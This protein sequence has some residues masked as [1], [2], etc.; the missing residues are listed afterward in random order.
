MRV[1]GRRDAF[2]TALRSSSVIPLLIELTR[3]VQSAMPNSMTPNILPMFSRATPYKR[4]EFKKILR[5]GQVSKWDNFKHQIKIS[6]KI[7]LLEHFLACYLPIA[8]GRTEGFILFSKALL[9]SE[10]QTLLSRIWTHVTNS[11]SYDNHYVNWN[12]ETKA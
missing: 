6:K 11:I 8:E 10:M 5:A 4:I 9:R 1:C 3:T 2:K 7:F 12:N